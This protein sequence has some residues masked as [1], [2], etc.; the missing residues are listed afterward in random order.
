[1]LL[2]PFPRRKKLCAAGAGVIIAAG[3]ASTPRNPVLDSYP[4]GIIGHTTV[5]Y[6]DVH[7]RTFDEVRADMRRLGPKVADSSF[8][9]ETRSPMRWSWRTESMNGSCSI[10]DVTVSVNAQVTL[11]RWTPP[12]DTE[13]GLAAEWARFISALETHEA[14]HK[15]ISA[16]AGSEIVSR[17]R[18]L[19]GGC[20]QL[21][22]RAND[23]ARV[24]VDKASDEQKTYDAVTRH[25]LTQGT[26]FGGGRTRVTVFTANSP[27]VLLTPPLPGTVR[28]PFPVAIDRAYTL[29]RGVYDAAGLRV[30]AADSSAHALGDSLTVHGMLARFQMTELVDCGTL[31]GGTTADSIDVTLF[32]TS[33]FSANPPAGSWMTNTVQAVA[34]PAGAPPNVC[35]SLGTLERF[36]ANSLRSRLARPEP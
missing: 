21:G 30:N 26:A 23:L 28:A 1:M 11:P 27:M 9:G 24:I 8:V 20:S 36:L 4:A 5:M 35:R 29:T 17:L 16:K 14:G 3:C 15:D 7:G 34:R 33:R 31:A 18:T 32:V 10:R 25:G 19:S 6:Y 22:T 12:A 2:N 13:P